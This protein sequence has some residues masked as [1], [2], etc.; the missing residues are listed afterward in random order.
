MNYLVSL[1]LIRDQCFVNWYTRTRFVLIR[2]D[3]GSN[4]NKSAHSLK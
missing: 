3:N 4:I 2:F 1:P